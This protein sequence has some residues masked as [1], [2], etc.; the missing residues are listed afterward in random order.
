[1]DFQNVI[2]KYLPKSLTADQES[3]IGVFDQFIQSNEPNNIMLIKG[4]AGTGKSTFTGAVV[5][6]IQQFDRNIILSAPTGRSAKVLSSFAGTNAY[7]LHKILYQV[8]QKEGQLVFRKRVNKFSRTIFV[9]DEASMIG[10][11]GSGNESSDLLND[12]MTYVFSQPK[13][14]LIIVG[15]SAQLP[16]VNSNES[17]ALQQDELQFYD[18]KIFEVELKQVVR[19]HVDSG[20]LKHAT[21]VRNSMSAEIPKLGLG[22]MIS[23]DVHFIDGNELEEEWQSM[24]SEYSIHETLIITRSNKRANMYNEHIRRNLLWRENKIEAGDLLMAVKNNYYWFKNQKGQDFIANGESLEVVRIQRYEERYDKHFAD[25]TV[26][27]VDREGNVEMDIKVML[28]TL[29]LEGPSMDTASMT[30]LFHQVSE[31]YSHITS[32]KKKLERIRNDE[33]LNAVQIKF[34]YAV[35]CHKSQGGQWKAVF[36]DCGFFNLEVNQDFLRWMY[37]AITRATHQLFYIS[38]PNELK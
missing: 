7:T 38:L 34:S 5:K 9:V 22:E 33:Y 24:V 1:M 8:V 10:Q 13:N 28:D 27:F 26:K 2:K 29:H 16:P 37:T 18:A 31:S 12:L 17:P 32:G 25:V 4:Y 3:L 21:Y 14:R 36:I 23:G 11:S 15:D 30:K 35:T 20:I 19:Q 6:F